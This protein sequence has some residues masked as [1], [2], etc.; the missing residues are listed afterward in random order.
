[1]YVNASLCQLLL[2]YRGEIRIDL[3]GCLGTLGCQRRWR[4]WAVWTDAPIMSLG[5]AHEE[6][7]YLDALGL[8]DRDCCNGRP[9]VRIAQQTRVC[10]LFASDRLR[11]C[12]SLD[13]GA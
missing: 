3:G 12:G 6:A 13:G 8:D 7:V 1:M 9:P 2:R 11:L 10:S 5:R 4:D